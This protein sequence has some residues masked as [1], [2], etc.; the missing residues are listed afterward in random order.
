MDQGS[1]DQKVGSKGGGKR[2]GKPTSARVEEDFLYSDLLGDSYSVKN[3]FLCTASIYFQCQRINI[4]SPG[5]AG[6]LYEDTLCS[7]GL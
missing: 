6:E 3:R 7:V 2:R 1:Q 5:K 4:K